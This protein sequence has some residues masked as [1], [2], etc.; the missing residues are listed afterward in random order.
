MSETKSQPEPA[1]TGV[2]MYDLLASCAAA[3]A[4]STPPRAPEPETRRP[5][6][7]HREAA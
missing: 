2:S 6:R 7:E 3:T 5:V 4:I 1:P